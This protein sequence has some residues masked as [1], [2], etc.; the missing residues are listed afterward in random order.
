MRSGR[1]TLAGIEDALGDIKR[2]EASL[3]QEL[4]AATRDRV[5][6]VADRLEALRRLASIRARDAMAD[7]VI[8]EAD[9]LTHQV[10]GILEARITTRQPAPYLTN[11]DYIQGHPF[12]VDERVIVPRSYIGEI[13]DLHFS[14]D[15][16]S[17]IE[18][19]GAVARVLDLC[20]GSGCLAVLAARAFP[21]ATIDAVDLSKKALQVAARNVADHGLGDRIAL[22]AGDLFAPLGGARYDLIISNPPYVD[23]GGMAELPREC[24]HEPKM[25]LDGG[26]DG[27]D[28]VQRILAGAP[29]HLAAG[30][31]LLCEVGRCRPALEAAFPDV[32]FLWLDSEDSEAEVFWL[33]AGA[34]G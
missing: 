29:D 7:G 21:N 5:K 24:R 10:R 4:E 31:G 19:P 11:R 22:H 27:I 25:A 23:A 2:Q 6:L 14:G 13:L 18:D 9:N 16:G 30:G 12:Y 15:P 33:E 32:P 3:A 28:I 34:I 1:E 8:D 17:L 26:R 20:T